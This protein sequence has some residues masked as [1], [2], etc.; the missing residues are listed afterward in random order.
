MTTNKENVELRYDSSEWK[1]YFVDDV[2]NDILAD[3]DE[4]VFAYEYI[5]KQKQKIRYNAAANL[6]V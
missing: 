2:K 1:E 6:L 5:H 3:E 4:Q